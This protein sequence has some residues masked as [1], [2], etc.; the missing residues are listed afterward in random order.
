LALGIFVNKMKLSQF[1][2]KLDANLIAQAPPKDRGDSRLLIFDTVSDKIIHGRFVDIV[3]FF[4]TGDILVLNN[5]KVMP[6]RLIGFK[7]STQGKIEVF[8]LRAQGVDVW[9]CLLGGHGQKLNL[10][11]EFSKG[12][13][14]HVIKH[15]DDGTWLVCFNKSKAD[16]LRV[17]QIIGR[18]PLPPYIKRAQPNDEDKYRYQTVYANNQKS[19]SVAAPTAGLHFTKTLLH[20]LQAKGVHIEYVTLHVG[21]GTFQPVKTSEIEDHH[22]HAEHVE[23]TGRALKNIISAKLQN[24]RIIA[25]G[26]TSVRAL[27]AV[28]TNYINSKKF[29]KVEAEVNIFIYPG[30]KFKIVDAMLTNFHLPKSTLLM[31]VAAFLQCRGAKDSIKTLKNIYRVAQ[32]KKYRFFSYGDAMFIK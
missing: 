28:A 16:L 20:Q 14:G 26:T 22:M 17:I 15:N 4:R 25:V 3:D 24:R 9:Q 29:S 18:M 12:L 27:E 23:I 2:Y 8:L 5:S 31:L 1:D 10:I 7:Q 11:I 6:A 30:Y 21:L 32:V 13:E 19:G